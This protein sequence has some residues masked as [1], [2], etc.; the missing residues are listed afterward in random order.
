MHAY[1]AAIDIN[2]VQNPYINIAEEGFIIW[3]GD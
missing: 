2:P 3:V 1:G